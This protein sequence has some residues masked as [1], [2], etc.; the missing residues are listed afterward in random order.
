MVIAVD[1]T[2]VQPVQAPDLGWT[3]K[4]LILLKRSKLSK[5]SNQIPN[6]IEVQT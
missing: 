5:V 4:C 3:Q 6:K 1:H 2:S